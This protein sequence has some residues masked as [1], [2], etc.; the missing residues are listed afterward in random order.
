VDFGAEFLNQSQALGDIIV[1]ADPGTPVPTCPGWAFKQLFRHV[2]K[3]NRWAAQIVGDRMQD[4]LAFA[5][6]RDGRAPND[7]AAARAWFAEGAQL[8]VD[9]VAEVGPDTQVW[10][11]TG[12][13][14]ASWW[15]RRRLHEVL[16]HRADAAVALGA[17]F[18]PRPELAADALS[19]W[20]D[21]VVTRMPDLAGRRVHLHASDDGLGEA[22]EW[23]IGNG[24]WAHAHGKGDVALRGPATD[25]LLVTTGRRRVGDTAVEVFGDEQLLTTWLDGMKF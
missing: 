18:A 14:P 23:T 5:D 7:P 1:D 24:G 19:D 25:L 22:G 3:G 12:P 10:T 15:L 2:G 11:F 17:E 13:K 8:L 20:F 21:L 4:A 9:A 6:I 16:V